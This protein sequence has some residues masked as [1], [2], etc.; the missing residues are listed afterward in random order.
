MNKF[1]K[2][3]LNKCKTLLPD[4]DDSTTELVI[5][6]NTKSISTQPGNLHIIIQ[7]YIINEPDNF[8]LSS[9]WNNGTTPPEPEM[10]VDIINIIGK[11]HKVKG[12]G[13]TTNKSWEG[14]LPQKGYK[15]LK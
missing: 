7:N 15:I 14:W 8:T 3:Q 10:V 4:W 5:S 6:N 9:N 1:I 13:I 2:Q 12:F 11:M